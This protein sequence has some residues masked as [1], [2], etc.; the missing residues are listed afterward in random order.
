MSRPIEFSRDEARNAIADA[1]AAHGY[2]GTTLAMLARASGLGKQS[3][4]N[5]FG[6][7][8]QMYLDAIDCSVSR[9]G[10]IVTKMNAAASGMAALEVCFDFLI[11]CCL[12]DAPSTSNC[13]VSNG[14]LSNA[15]DETLH[16]AHCARWADSQALLKSVILRGQKDGS[17]LPHFTAAAGADVLMSHMS[18]FRVSARVY[19]AQGSAR[20]A[21][22][23]LQQVKV[24]ALSTFKTGARAG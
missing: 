12:S 4:Y 24:A 23:R 1:F 22:S 20:S 17:I 14:L 11:A 3:L 5:A 2:E 9:F 10:Q 15:E 6:D 16:D 18:G 21:Q 8:E 13:I 7:K 19:L